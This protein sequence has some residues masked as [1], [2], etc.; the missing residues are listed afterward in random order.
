MDLDLAIFHFINNTLSNPIFDVIMPWWTDVQKTWPFIYV[1]LP[2]L[3]VTLALKKNWK[4]IKAI[5]LTVVVVVFANNLNH[6]LVKRYFNR[7]RPAQAILRVEKPKNPSFPSGHAVSSFTMAM[8]LSLVFRRYKY[9]F[10]SLA[11]LTAFSRIYLGVHY[12]SDVVAGALFGSLIAYSFYKLITTF[13]PRVLSSIALITFSLSAS[14]EWKD[15]TEGKP[16]FPWVWEDQ[17]KPT[18]DK[19]IEPDSL[20][21]LGVGTSA[22]VAARPFDHKVHDHNQVHP[23]VFGHK[24][25]QRFGKIGNGALGVGIALT[26]VA[27]DTDNGLRHSRAILLTSVSHISIASMVRR[28][29]P[30]NRQDFLPFPSSFPSGHASSAF[31]TAGSLAYSYGW[32]AGV[33]AY[34]VATSIGI[35]RIR[36]NRHWL[37]DVVGGAFLGSYWARASF[38]VKKEKPNPEE[39]YYVPSPIYDGFM[40]TAIKEF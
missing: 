25:A 38:N 11:S 30:G 36:E 34:L 35:S 22:T 24:E 39:V 15:P 23:I 8:F 16:I 1:F 37:S 40:L 26:Q 21:F 4:A 32:K 9:L 27:F 17:L 10:L 29:R 13:T 5:L 20:I 2:V 12:P 33:P 14:A 19:A 7:E 28:N 6:L 31:A 3:L 18:L